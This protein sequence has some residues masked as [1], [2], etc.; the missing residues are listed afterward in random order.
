MKISSKDVIYA[1]SPD[2]KAAA[3]VAPGSELTFETF[4]CFCNQ[5][6]S[7]ED[8]MEA[9]DWDRINP[10]TGPV[11]IEG[12][13]AGDLLKVQIKSIELDEK[14]TVVAGEGMGVLAKELQ[15]V[16]TKIVKIDGDFA[17][18][19]DK[20]KIPLRKMIGVIGV[21]PDGTSI[22]TGTPGCH[23]G[24]MDNTMVTE[25][26][27]VY[28]PV[29]APGALL[30]LGDVHATMGDGE[31]GVSGLEI[32]A[33][34]TVVVDLIKG[35][36]TKYPML[37]NANTWSV[38]ASC[39]NLDQAAEEATIEMFG[40]LNARMDLAPNEVT[41]LMSLAGNLEVCQVVD[42]LKTMRFV[43]DK[44]IVGELSI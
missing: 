15:G 1:F 18:F 9:L 21:A 43:V 39:E 25:G 37:E 44:S 34:V 8:K 27:T 19:T 32:P 17:S 4:D 2:N 20:I 22:N 36:A 35:K 26:A 28:L 7:P 41:M 24:N 16:S 33:K 38:I 6:R 13:E 42:P 30:G 29:S 12:A 5:L 11:F 14:G 23:G 10:A 40:F 3:T 31:I